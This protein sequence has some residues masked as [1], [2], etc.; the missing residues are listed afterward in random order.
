[1]RFCHLIYNQCISVIWY[2]TSVFQMCCT[3]TPKIICTGACVIMGVRV[4]YILPVG[5]ILISGFNCVEIFSHLDW[6][7]LWAKVLLSHCFRV[8][9]SW[10][11]ILFTDMAPPHAALAFFGGRQVTRPK[12]AGDWTTKYIMRRVTLAFYVSDVFIWTMLGGWKGKGM[13]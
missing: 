9:C 11:C 12:E 1:M 3:H 4:E 6:S 10:K 5:I 8:F 2:I 13:V 7:V